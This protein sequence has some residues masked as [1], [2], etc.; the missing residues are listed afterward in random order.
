MV[1]VYICAIQS[2]DIYCSCKVARA[3][4][5]VDIVITSIIVYLLILFN[6]FSKLKKIIDNGTNI[7]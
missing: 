6:Y 2:Q 4:S 1:V 3:K 5:G 7:P